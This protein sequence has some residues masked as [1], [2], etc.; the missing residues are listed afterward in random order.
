MAEHFLLLSAAKALL[1]RLLGPSSPGSFTSLVYHQQS[2]T[3]G[4]ARIF[5][6]FRGS[7]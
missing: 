5:M 6:V 3:T 1:S 4:T 7:R 2:T